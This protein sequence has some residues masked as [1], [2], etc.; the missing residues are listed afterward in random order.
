MEL[1]NTENGQFQD[2]DPSTLTPGTPLSA[3]WANNIQGEIAAVIIDRG[4]VLDGTKTN[5]MST[6]LSDMIGG[7]LP[8][9][10]GTITGSL[11]IQTV[12]ETDNST[13]AASTAFVQGLISAEATARE[14]ADSLLAPKASPVF[15]GQV[16]MPGGS[17]TLTPSAG[18]SSTNVATTAFVDN[19]LSSYTPTANLPLDPGHLIQSGRSNAPGNITFST[20]FSDTPVSI[21]VTPITTH[22]DLYISDQSGTGYIVHTVDGQSGPFFWMAIG[23][24]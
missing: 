13:N 21:V 9:T 10:G 17:T 15:S 8:L 1:I 3:S 2:A 18:D 4:G 12:A 5:Q 16:Q 22:M 24:K 19:A 20:A 7:Y 14:N 6:I 11:N 23:P